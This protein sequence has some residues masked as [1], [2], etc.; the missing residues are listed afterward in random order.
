MVPDKKVT[1]RIDLSALYLYVPITDEGIF[2]YSFAIMINEGE[3]SSV[4]TH[5]Y[6]ASQGSKPREPLILE[7]GTNLERNILNYWNRPLVG[8]LIKAW[9]NQAFIIAR[10]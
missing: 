10:I 2:V 1:R 8:R 7:A 4:D 9:Q 6:R 3:Y 5:K